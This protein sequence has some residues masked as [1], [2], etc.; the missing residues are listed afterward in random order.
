M[1]PAANL[2]HAGQ[3]VDNFDVVVTV[4]SA[5]SNVPHRPVDIDV[6]V[7]RPLLH[8]LFYTFR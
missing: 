3:F 6:D 8:A 1:L 4:T 2:L 7:G 5:C